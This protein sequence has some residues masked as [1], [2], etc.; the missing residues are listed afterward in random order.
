[1]RNIMGG[2]WIIANAAK[3]VKKENVICHKEW[4]DNSSGVAEVIVLLELLAAIESKGRH[5]EFGEISIR[6]DHRKGFKKIVNQIKKSSVYAQ[7][8]GAKISRIKEL[9]EK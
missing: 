3:S 6:F 9:I 2:C 8:A 5:I 4:E 1:M 7:E